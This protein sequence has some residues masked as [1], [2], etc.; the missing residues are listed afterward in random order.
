MSNEDDVVVEG[1]DDVVVEDEDDVVEVDRAE[2]SRGA[3]AALG[4]AGV[5]LDDDAGDRDVV[6]VDEVRGVEIDDIAAER[7]E[8]E[9]HWSL[10]KAEQQAPPSAPEEDPTRM[11]DDEQTDAAR[12]RLVFDAVDLT[13]GDEHPIDRRFNYEFIDPPNTVTPLDERADEP[14]P[15]L[16]PVVPLAPEP[17]IRPVH[18]ARRRARP[19]VVPPQTIEPEPEPEP[20]HVVPPLVRVPEPIEHVGSLGIE[21]PEAWERPEPERSGRPILPIAIALIPAMLLSFAAGYFV[22]GRGD[23]PQATR[24]AAPATQT[25]EATTP[26]SPP[27]GP[28]AK[29]FSE[30]TVTP[31][32]A[33]TAKPP[34]AAPSVPG[35]VPAPGP[36]TTPTTETAR[37]APAAP[38]TGKLQVRSN[39]SGASVTLNGAWRGRTPLALDDL[40][41]G[42]YV[43]RVVS[44]GYDVAREDITL[45]SAAATGNISVRLQR[46]RTAAATKPAPPPRQQAPPARS[47]TPSAAPSAPARPTSPLTGSIYV[48]SRPRGAKVF[49]NGKEIGNTPIQI[50]EVRIG[51]HV[52]RLQLADHR[53][54]SNSVS[55][56]AGRES[57]VSGSLEPIIVK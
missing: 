21:R 6:E 5:D 25:A 39:P 54:W 36:G 4:V 16:P 18:E 15:P 46:Q 49:I 12:D 13:L 7:E 38:A 33:T 28:P 10:T 30:Q 11:F 47:T 56:S 53:I 17:P 22:R 43:V 40:A 27:P 45:S 20:E 37:P 8:D 34:A 52:I 41:F 2:P 24:S 57:R 14:P 51:S 26:A 50:P 19:I 35:D 55:V 32:P 48:D 3:S 31:P 1:E 29:P 44:P 42:N 23:A 9:A